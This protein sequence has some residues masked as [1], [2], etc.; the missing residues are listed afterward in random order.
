M[1]T[2]T[3]RHTHIL[4]IVT[5]YD[6]SLNKNSPL[7]LVRYFKKLGYLKTTVYLATLSFSVLLVL[8]L[9]MDCRCVSGLPGE[10]AHISIHSYSPL[11]GSPGQTKV[12]LGETMTFTE[13]TYRN[14]GEQVLTKAEVNH[15]ELHRQSLSQN[16]YQL[17]MTGNV[18]DTMQPAVQWI[19]ECLFK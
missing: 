6:F 3:H 2:H 14:L 16:G 17:I 9:S 18:E 4:V 8:V 7:R 1:H 10:I 13:V 12:Q 5:T 19:R 11:V 15:R